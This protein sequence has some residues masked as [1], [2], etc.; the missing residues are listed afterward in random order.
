MSMYI[1]E[2]LLKCLV[3]M[4]ILEI[5]CSE[6]SVKDIEGLNHFCHVILDDISEIDV[7][8]KDGKIPYISVIELRFAIKFLSK[9]RPFLNN[10]SKNLTL[11]DETI[12]ILLEDILK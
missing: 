5:E 12:E 11:I 4:K 7:S 10:E 9:I 6:L 1:K 2:N 8:W 3:N